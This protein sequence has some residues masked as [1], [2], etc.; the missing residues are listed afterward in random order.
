MNSSLLDISEDLVALQLLIEEYAEEHDG[1]I[2]P[3]IAAT[4]DAW[5][6]DISGQFN[7]KLDN[8]ATLIRICTLRAAA[9]KEEK[10]RLEK[11][12]RVDENMIG[13]LKERLKMIFEARKLPKVETR[14]YKIWVQKNGGKQPLDLSAITDVSKQLPLKYQVV[15]VEANTDALRESLEAGEV[16][17]GVKLLERGT[18]VRIA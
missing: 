16:V 15:R 7:D 17:E 10:E 4:L 18:H 11:R 3:E 8:Y 1:E 6:G 2:S 9:R 13:K 5:F 12:V 14:R